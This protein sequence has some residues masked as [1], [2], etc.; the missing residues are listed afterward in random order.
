LWHKVSVA[1]SRKRITRT[2]ALLLL[3]AP[4]AAQNGEKRVVPLDPAQRQV[5]ERQRSVGVAILVGVTKY[6]RYSGLGELR[7]PGRDVDLLEKELAR[8]RYTV[9]SLKDGEATRGAVLNAIRQAGEVVD[10]KDGT[11]VFFFSGHGFADQSA[12]FLAT[13][14]ATSAGLAQSG[15]SLAAVEEALQ[16]SG[17]PRRVMWIDACRNDP[18]KGAGEARGFERFAASGG[19]RVLFSTKA[20]RISYEDDELQQGLFSYY[21]VKGL[22]G[23]AARDDGIVSF[24]DLADFVTEGVQSRSLKQGRVQ[25]PYEAGE[26]SGDFL[27]ARVSSEAA[28]DAPRPVEMQSAGARLL[29]PPE[30]R[31]PPAEQ[32]T[33]RVNVK[34]LDPRGRTIVGLIASD[35]RIKEDGREQAITEFVDAAQSGYT[36]GYRPAR[37]VGASGTHSFAVELKSKGFKYQILAPATVDH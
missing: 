14:D 35:F 6:P 3:A 28:V 13:F 17:A 11:I 18:G 25:V 30:L 4:G 9:V 21:L 5:F 10:Q 26:S 12:N 7:Y 16:V 29:P 24:R 37:G 36:L 2:I 22:R 15:L 33:I 23:E 8:Q 1:L 31:A 20:G 27:L 19:T 32:V 34:I